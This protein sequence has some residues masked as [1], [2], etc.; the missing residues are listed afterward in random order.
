[1]ALSSP[2]DSVAAEHPFGVIEDSFDADGGVLGAEHGR[3]PLILCSVFHL[4]SFG[5]GQ[6]A[7]VPPEKD[8][9]SLQVEI[10]VVDNKVSIEGILR[11][12]DDDGGSESENCAQTNEPGTLSFHIVL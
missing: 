6:V 10:R 11:L 5:P 4:H 1:L 12:T 2:E 7:A 3:A 9:C 8:S